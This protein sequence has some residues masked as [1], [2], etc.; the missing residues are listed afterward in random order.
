MPNNEVSGARLLAAAQNDR[1][2][3]CAHITVRYSPLE[4]AGAT[5]ERWRCVAC[6]SPFTRGSLT[7]V[8]ALIAGE[9]ERAAAIAEVCGHPEIAAKI[10]GA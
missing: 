9:R 4:I 2:A 8:R 7:D 1:V 3:A 10:R 6:G 5:F